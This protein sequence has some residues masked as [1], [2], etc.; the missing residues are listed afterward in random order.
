VLVNSSV[1]VS[2]SV[3]H[4]EFI[5]I[6]VHIRVLVDVFV[7]ALSPLSFLPRVVV[8]VVA[9]TF[10]AVISVRPLLSD[11]ILSHRAI[12]PV[13]KGVLVGRVRI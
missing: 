4:I 6:E 11:G 10:S 3:S 2:V 13:F 7:Y 9:Y 12:A 5:L 8:I 1:S